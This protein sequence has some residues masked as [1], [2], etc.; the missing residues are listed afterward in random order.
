MRDTGVGIE[1]AELDRIFNR[2]YQSEPHLRRQYEGMGLGLA[3]AKEL[4][5]LH[6]G[7]VWAKSKI[8]AGSEFF[9]ALPMATE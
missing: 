7:R 1:E 4:I 3:I 2:F 6:G 9:V 8:G 5:E